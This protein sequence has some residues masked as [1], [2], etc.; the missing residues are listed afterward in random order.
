MAN[1]LRR[2]SLCTRGQGLIE[3]AFLLGLVAG[4]LV[5]VLLLLRTSTADTYNGVGNNLSQVV[6][7]STA[8]VGAAD[9]SGSSDAT[10]GTGGTTAGGHGHHGGGNGQGNNGNGNGN[11][12]GNGS[13]GNGGG[14]GNN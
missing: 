4:G 11:G 5:S 13:N 9:E 7:G 3:Y 12:G 6:A 1:W 10:A 2:W 8:G 14:Q